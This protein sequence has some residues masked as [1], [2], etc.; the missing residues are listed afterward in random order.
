VGGLGNNY[1]LDIPSFTTSVA[2]YIR[3]K[4]KMAIPNIAINVDPAVTVA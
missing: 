2:G 4:V 3:F 1:S